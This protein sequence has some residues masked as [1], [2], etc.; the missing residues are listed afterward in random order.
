[1]ARIAMVFLTTIVYAASLV[2]QL[3]SHVQITLT[4]IEHLLEDALAE[5]QESTLI[6][7]LTRLLENP[8]DINTASFD[9]LCQVPGID[10]VLAR[11]IIDY[12]A[13]NRI[14]SIDE[15][16]H[17]EG[18][19][20]KLVMIVRPFVVTVQPLSR[21]EERL[22]TARFRSR[23]VHNLSDH[24]AVQRGE[25]LGGEEKIATRI[26]AAII[27]GPRPE[28]L[29]MNDGRNLTLNVGLLVEKDPGEPNYA[30]FIS[31]YAAM[32][33]QHSGVSLILG[34]Y[35]VDAS[36][37]EVFSSDGIF[38]GG[39][40]ARG[41]ENRLRESVRPVLASE[42]SNQW[43]GVALAWNSNRVNCSLI[44]SFR[45]RDATIDSSGV[46][47]AVRRDGYHRTE[48]EIAARNQVQ[49]TSVGTRVSAEPANGLRVGVS[50]RRSHYNRELRIYRDGR[51]QAS[52]F[53]FG[54]IDMQVTSGS[55]LHSLEAAR[56]TGGCQSLAIT[57]KWVAGRT[58]AATGSLRL[59]LEG[60]SHRPTADNTR[61]Q[62][63]RTSE[64]GIAAK[65]RVT[66]SVRI[67]AL[68]E[69]FFMA[70]HPSSN[71]LPGNGHDLLCVGDIA[72]RKGIDL[73]LR[74]RHKLKPEI[75]LQ[76]RGGVTIQED[77]RTA[78][79]HL[80]VSLTMDMVKGA[81]SRTRIERTEVRRQAGTSVD[82]GVL[83]YQECSFDV[84]E[85]GLICLRCIA[86]ETTAYD[87]RIYEF[88]EELPGAYQSP[89]LY[90]KGL[91]WFCRGELRFG[92]WLRVSMKYARTQFLT[93]RSTELFARGVIVR[94]DER[95]AIQCD[96]AW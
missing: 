16:T 65:M 59:R 12:R 76:S 5:G 25:Y 55:F 81:R 2:A 83:M 50:F 6:E 14:R 93:P 30:D 41:G 3:G 91:R 34:D 84:M 36:Q 63:S 21:V 69:R 73:E 33:L 18:I 4:E 52:E 26:D 72:L 9:A 82:R 49:E 78:Q 44:T 51:E 45:S 28:G 87:A 57:S 74:Y 85:Q 1:M 10:P 17:I 58:F 19:D 71:L 60:D 88:E 94:Q 35:S 31:G 47:V 27:R 89:A 40:V 96:I 42:M 80:R 23:I 92:S 54:G 24:Q 29:H 67:S 8:L 22:P 43:R 20:E 46:V 70:R 39:F 53:F 13:H 7:D 90:G 64:V 48:D 86:F 15:L 11:K 75:E 32:K 68:F 79:S 66:S 56:W 38:A 95:W 37:G 61:W 62:A 77:G